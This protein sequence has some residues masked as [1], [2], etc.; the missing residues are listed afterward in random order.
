MKLLLDTH[1]LLWM[2]DDAPMLT[3]TARRSISNAESVHFSPVSLWEIGLK[4]RAGK[5]KAQPSEVMRD[6]I[7]LSVMELPV[8]NESIFI[9]CEMRQQHPDPFDRLL[10][11]QAKHH[12]MKFLTADRQ[13]LAFGTTV[14][15]KL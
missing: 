15:A 11:A 4:W 9:S 14:I 8:A 6:L 5:L 12:K 7:A 1:I 2:I 13:R 3:A 10:Y